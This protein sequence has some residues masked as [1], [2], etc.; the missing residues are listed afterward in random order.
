M[1]AVVTVLVGEV[2]RGLGEA[3]GGKAPLQEGDVVAAT[4]VPVPPPDDPHPHVRG[5]V[6]GHVL[7]EEADGV[8][9]TGSVVGGAA[10]DDVV[11]EHSL[12]IRAR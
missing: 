6:L 5:V 11:G 8:R 3:R 4:Q 1:V 9:I 7:D 12:D 10:P 2:L